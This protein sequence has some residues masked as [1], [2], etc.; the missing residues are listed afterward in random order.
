MHNTKDKLKAILAAALMTG[1]LM[2]AF[3]VGVSRELCRRDN[4]TPAQY[5]EMKL[6]CSFWLYR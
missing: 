2:T 1:F 5:A 3:Y 4:I 6:D